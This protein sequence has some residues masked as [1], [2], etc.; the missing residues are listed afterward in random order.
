M[1][2]S[3]NAYA[4]PLTVSQAAHLLR[5][6]TFGILPT[7]IKQFS[8]IS[9]DAATKILLQI[10]PIPAPPLNPDTG[11]TFHDQPFESNGCHSQV[12][13]KNSDKMTLIGEACQVSDFCLTVF[14]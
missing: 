11:K 5:R 7:Q 1:N 3:L 8:G 10:P 14:A 4:Q 2:Y 12:F 13:F 9:A 6:A